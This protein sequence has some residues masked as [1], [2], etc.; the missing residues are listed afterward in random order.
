MSSNFI[1]FLIGALM[2]LCVIVSIF[3]SIAYGIPEGHPVI[4]GMI[5]GILMVLGI[6]L[7]VD[8]IINIEA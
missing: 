3:Y 6:S 8:S 1:E 7:L 5:A 2:V 4:Y